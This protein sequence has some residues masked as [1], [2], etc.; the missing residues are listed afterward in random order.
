VKAIIEDFGEERFRS[1]E[2]EVLKELAEGEPRLVSC[3]GGV[4]LKQENRD[5]LRSSGFVVYL[6][7]TAREAASRI[8]DK[9]TRPLFGG[10]DH[11]ERVIAG[12][13]HLYEEV[14]D[15]TI[16]TAGR[17]SASV[18]REALSHLNATGILK[19]EG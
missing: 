18:A 15:V 7:V 10:L 14:A 4:V 17:G 9:T 16:D 8:S 1:I 2:T 11:A 3:G 19:V 12:R 6:Q 13:L 5:I